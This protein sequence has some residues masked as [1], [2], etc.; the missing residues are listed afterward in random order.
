MP[1]IR[2]LLSGESYL[3]HCW[4]STHLNQY[5]IQACGIGRAKKLDWSLRVRFCGPCWRTKSVRSVPYYGNVLIFVV[6]KPEP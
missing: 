5:G 6:S 1:G 2:T 3:W 4:I